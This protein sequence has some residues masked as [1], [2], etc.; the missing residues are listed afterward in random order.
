MA[1][2]SE[3]PLIKKLGIKTGNTL[4]F[5]NEPG[6]YTDLLGKL[7]ENVE[8]VGPDHPGPVNFIH[9]FADNKLS[10]HNFFPPCIEKLDK[11]GML[12][13]SW[14]KQSS[15]LE[16][17]IKGNDVRELGLELGLVDVK[18]CAVDKDWSGLKFMYRKEDR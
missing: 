18:V 7:P 4:M 10:L 5:V 9:I 14:I 2:Y 3:T 17:D 13:V 12:W 8:V 1:G 16:T 11:N 6:H 15:R